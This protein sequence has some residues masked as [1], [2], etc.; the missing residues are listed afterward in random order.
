MEAGVDQA[1]RTLS[2]A[3]RSGRPNTLSARTGLLHTV[4]RAGLRERPVGFTSTG[5]SRNPARGK[6][7]TNHGQGLSA[8]P[9][10]MRCVVVG[11]AW[12]GLTSG[13]P[14]SVADGTPGLLVVQPR[15]PLVL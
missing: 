8:G 13:K 4:R 3:A 2:G 10:E 11:G 6:V 9:R 12:P 5:R 14:R 1:E 7:P 15:T